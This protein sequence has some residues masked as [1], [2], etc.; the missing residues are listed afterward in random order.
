MGSRAGCFALSGL[1]HRAFLTQGLRPFD[2]L[3]AGSAPGCILPPLRGWGVG[4][5]E[6]GGDAG[7]KQVPPRLRRFGMT[8]LN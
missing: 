7:K 4:G 3:R 5:S 1:C 2:K 6:R 8:S